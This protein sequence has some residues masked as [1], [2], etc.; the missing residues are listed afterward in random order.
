MTIRDS[1]LVYLSPTSR[2]LV[3]MDSNVLQYWCMRTQR[4]L[5]VWEIP[6]AYRRPDYHDPASCLMCFAEDKQLL[7]FQAPGVTAKTK[8]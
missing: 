7:K 8:F 4:S 6:T 2:Y 3:S 5:G 1:R